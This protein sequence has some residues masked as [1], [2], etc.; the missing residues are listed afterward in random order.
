MTGFS[1]LLVTGRPA[2]VS[3]FTQLGQIATP[4]FAVTHLPVSTVVNG[5]VPYDDCVAAATLAVVDAGPDPVVAFQLCQALRAQRPALP[6]AALICCPHAVTPWQLRMLVAAGVSNVLDLQ[7]T[8]EEVLRALQGIACGE[9]VLHVQLKG[10]HGAADGLALGQCLSREMGGAS[11]WN[12]TTIQ[13][14]ELL[15]HGLTDQEIGLDLNLSPHTIKHRIERVREEVGARNR[16]ELAA[17]A[18]WQGF[19]R[20]APVAPAEP[21]PIRVG[22]AGRAST[23]PHRKRCPI[24]ASGPATFLVRAATA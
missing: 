17:W 21:L 22:G 9:V 8:S 14:L 10:R 19:Y 11:S 12:T 5:L 3:Y 24:G 1:V 15:V 6:L 4:P 7:A 23:A 2:V 13:L 18:S 20:P 16:I